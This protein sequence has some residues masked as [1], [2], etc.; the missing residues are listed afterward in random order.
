MPSL[1]RNI[2]T[3][4]QNEV[5]RKSDAER[6]FNDP[7][8][9]SEY[10]LNIKLWSKQKE[11]AED[12][13]AC[14]NVAVKAGHGTGKALTLGTPMPT[15]TGW[16]TM[17]EVRVG[18]LLLDEQGKPTP[19]VAVSET[20]NED[21]YRVTFDDG[22]FVDAAAQHEWSVIDIRHRPK[23]VPVGDWRNR[24]DAATVKETRELAESVE[25]GGQKRWR[26]PLTKPLDLPEADLPVDPYVFGAWLGDGHSHGAVLT[27]HTD[28]TEIRSRFDAAGYP[29]RKIAGKY[30]WSFA[31]KGKFVATIR[32]LGV[33][34]NKHIPLQF[35]RASI[36]QR[37]E[38]LRGLMD[39]DGTIDER[40]LVSIDLCS[41]AL[42]DGVVELVRSLGGKVTIRERDAVLY[43]KVVGTRWRMSIRVTDF[44]P[45]FL[46]RKASRWIAPTG[47]ASRYTQKTIVSVEQIE[48]APTRCVE[49]ASPNHLFLAG[50]GMVPTHNSFLLAI[51]IVWWLD[52]RYPHAFIASTAPSQAQIGAIVWRYVR[53][54]KVIIE[55]RHKEGLIDHVLPGYITADNQWK[56][57]G[58]NILG[59]GRK[60]PENKEDDS[61][62]GIHDSYV[63][64]VGD[65]AVGLTA[66]LIDSLGNIT[67]NE[68]SRRVLI[69]NP[70]N[71]ASY[72]G[73][74]FKDKTP[75]WRFHTISVFDSPKITGDIDGLSE[76]HLKGL[77]DES[78]VRDKKAEYGENTARYKARVLG[79]FAW[80]L[81]NT[82]IQ[83]D[84]LATAYDTKIQPDSESLITLGVDI[85]RFGEDKSCIYLNEG[86]RL[87]LLKSFDMNSLVELAGEVH[88]AACDV[89]AHEVRY[90]YQGVGQG[91]EEMLL[92]HEPRPYKMIGM[93]S[94]NP[95]PDRHQWANARAWWWDMFRKMLR[96][97]DLD[98]EPTDE[99]LS[100]EL[101]SVE[102]KFSP[103]GGLL[104]ESKDEMKKRGM[105]SPDFA[106]AA[107]YASVDLTEALN[108][109]ARKANAFEDADT[110]MGEAVPDYL[111]LMVQS[112]DQGTGWESRP[113]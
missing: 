101:L 50:K 65:E 49:V 61:F 14:K 95:S 102:Y 7:A 58:G 5:R 26:V 13:V 100:D 82:L 85:A 9:W 1:Y 110:I 97:G 86:G 29:L 42:S 108:P 91:F 111:G 46:S 88:K 41:K 18:D 17:G 64:A 103:L 35:L 43:G 74:L 89:G 19:V 27:S 59:F 47:Q 24:W 22:T 33:Y 37:R 53:Q 3:L 63:L 60:P 77:V 16:T 72:V 71:P 39:T 96:N 12:I 70:T 93:I 113:W 28:D 76:E 32:D 23:R 20:W 2:V 21:T 73:K 44:N 84:D 15:P 6:Y 109:Q 8:A 105:K 31:D 94:S 66:E 52:T 67:S 36:D 45:F 78:Y 68:G 40:G 55:K 75:T 10:M 90:D 51:I 56:E 62:Q 107:V 25:F 54:L 99:R 106:D 104:I 81:G 87:K 48:T 38:L 80:D 98:I 92:M 112:W 69:C 57:D 4:A 11:I 34:R 83:P 30:A 79:E